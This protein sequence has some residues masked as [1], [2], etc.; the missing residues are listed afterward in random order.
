MEDFECGLE[1]QKGSIAYYDCEVQWG[2]LM[3][4]FHFS[5]QESN[6][7]VT[8]D[9]LLMFLLTYDLAGQLS[10]VSELDLSKCGFVSWN[11]A[12]IVLRDEGLPQAKIDAYISIYKMF[13]S[14]G[15]RNGVLNGED[16][17]KGLSKFET[18]KM[19]F[20]NNKLDRLSFNDLD[21]ITMD[22]MEAVLPED[23]KN[24]ECRPQPA[25]NSVSYDECAM[26]DQLIEAFFHM[27]DE[28]KNGV[29][30]LD[31]L[32]EFYEDFNPSMND[33]QAALE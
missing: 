20:L 27:A 32:I 7:M 24:W 9:E 33:A 18:W 29:V 12:A 14:V 16:W 30:P 10:S 21:R 4:M 19:D 6:G 3:A 15:D 2:L 23:C 28:D 1:P 31:Q 11:Q 5:D 25:A 8:R 13:D 22:Q 26:E 17:E